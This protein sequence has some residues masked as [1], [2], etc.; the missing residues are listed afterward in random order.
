M[1]LHRRNRF[2]N[3]DRIARLDPEVD[4]DEILALTSRHDFP[5][6]YQQGTGIAFM[7]DYGIPSIA[8]LL[9]RTGEF[10]HHGVKR[11]DDTLLV[12]DQAT[13][14]GIDSP[15]SHATLRRLNRIHG[16]YAI[17]E[18]EFHYVLA[19]TIVGPV[20]WIREYGW[21]DLHP[22]EL[23]AIARITTRFGELMGLRGLPTTY[24]G[25]LR[26]LREY[27]AEHFAHTPAATRLAEATI[28]I[29]RTTAPLPLKPLTRRVAIAMMDE[30]LREALGMPRQPAW[31][32]ATLRRSLK[33]RARYLRHLAAPRTDAVPTPADDVPARLHAGR[34]RPRVDARGAQRGAEAPGLVVPTS[35]P[36]PAAVVRP[37]IELDRRPRRSRPASGH[38]PTR[39]PGTS[40]T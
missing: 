27:E 29:G 22:H 40:T 1:R 20:E 24:D 36:S 17:P 12:G 21:R 5:W 9:D 19:T 26:L 25:Y 35:R 6:D 38:C 2:A 14:D 33:L 32:V 3:L 39:A 30:P 15:R 10:E 23:L 13:I 4:A 34:P 28:R 8:A 7:R 18:H 11:Y 16:H 31:F 37:R